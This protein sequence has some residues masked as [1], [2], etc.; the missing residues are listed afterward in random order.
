[1]TVQAQI[2]R[3]LDAMRQGSLHSA[4]QGARCTINGQVASPGDLGALSGEVE[5]QPAVIDRTAGTG[6]VFTTLAGNDSERPVIIGLRIGTDAAD[7]LTEL[8]ILRSAEGQSSIFGPERLVS[9]RNP[10]MEEPLD[11]PGTR[12]HS[13]AAAH[14]YFSDLADNTAN[15]RFR[16]S[17]QRVENGVQT[18]G[19]PKILGGSTCHQQMAQGWFGYITNVRG[20]RFPVVD[21]STGVVTAVA[22]LDVPGTV[23]HLDLPEDK[24]VELPAQMRFPRSTLLFE[25]FKVDGEE[26]V[27]IE[28]IMVNLDFGAPHGWETG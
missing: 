7:G 25:Q 22:F 19:N 2:D 23:T 24:R 1:M 12:K 21:T 5:A 20:R 10:V 17:C 26:L 3:L 11:N 18:T 15:S 6:V 16:P 28:A 9:H 4:A 8:E 27:W 13:I 14:Q